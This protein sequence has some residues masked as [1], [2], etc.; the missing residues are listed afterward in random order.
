MNSGMDQNDPPSC[1]HHHHDQTAII[2]IIIVIINIIIII[3]ITTTTTII[4]IIII[5][6]IIVIPIIIIITITNDFRITNLCTIIT[7]YELNYECTGF[8][9]AF[10]GLLT[11]LVFCMNSSAADILRGTM[12][13]KVSMHQ[14]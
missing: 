12:T 14:L 6:I 8:S 13:F 5:I 11:L 10:I 1:S 9:V 3:I 7:L 2:I 4:I